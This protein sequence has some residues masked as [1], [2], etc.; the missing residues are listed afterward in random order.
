[1]RFIFC[2]VFLFI[3]L[4]LT[5]CDQVRQ[6]ISDTL[7]PATPTEMAARMDGLTNQSKAE[8]AIEQGRNY[9]KFN[10]D[11]QDLVNAALK[12]AYTAAG[13]SEAVQ[14]SNRAASFEEA[15]DSVNAPNKNTFQNIVEPQPTNRVA[16]DGASV[17]SGPNGT[18]VRAGDAVV[19]MP[20]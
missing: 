19:I 20:K 16:V 2:L 3:G 7:S 13:Q 11:P 14:D 9:L 6:R 10:K 4:N 8:D 15:K 5:G 12:R 18:V 1:M 17:T